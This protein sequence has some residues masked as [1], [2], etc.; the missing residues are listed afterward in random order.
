MQKLITVNEF[1]S[2]KDVGEK[3][4]DKK[5]NQA[6]EIAQSTDLKDL[7]G[8]RFYFDMMNNLEQA[9]YQDLLSGCTFTF[10]GVTYYQDGIKALLTDYTMAKYAL[11]INTNF[12]PFGATVKQSNDSEPADRNSL[13]DISTQQTQLAG[14]RWETIK[15]YLDTNIPKYPNWVN[16]IYGGAEFINSERTF[17]IRKI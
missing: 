11:S 2:V 5:I 15:L 7:L 16:N 12:T 6:I 3:V 10:M 9:N 14:S 17:R 13:K 8:S 1:K 4:D